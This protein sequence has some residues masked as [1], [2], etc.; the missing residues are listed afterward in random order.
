MRRHIRLRRGNAIAMA[1]EWLANDSELESIQNA[2][3][4][5]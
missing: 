1:N 5:N 4:F 3:V 2:V